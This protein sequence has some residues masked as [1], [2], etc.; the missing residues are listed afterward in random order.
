[1]YQQNNYLYFN[2]TFFCQIK[3][4]EQQSNI[5]DTTENQRDIDV[6]LLY[7]T[8]KKIEQQII[9][10][11]LNL[12]NEIV[13]DVIDQ[14]DIDQSFKLAI[15]SSLTFQS[16][17]QPQKIEPKHTMSLSNV[18]IV[19]NIVNISIDGSSRTSTS[20]SARSKKST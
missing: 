10:L 12:N 6:R 1:M 18:S 19:P 8:N 16:K 3:R 13:I 5:Y 15:K 9:A 7:E 17:Q 4:F 14:L 11:C 2:L 20:E